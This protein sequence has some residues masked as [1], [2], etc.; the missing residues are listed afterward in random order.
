MKFFV[1]RQPIFDRSSKVF[2]Y[3]LLFRTGV[4]M[5]VPVISGSQASATVISNSFLNLG[6]EHFTGGKRAFINFTPDLIL[7]QI[8]TL[9][10]KEQIV[11]E[12]IEHA[13]PTPE[14]LRECAALKDAGYMIALDDYDGGSRWRLFVEFADIIKVDFVATSG[15][16]RKRLAR[17]L[18]GGQAMLLAEKVETMTEYQ[19]AADLGFSAFQG[20][21]FAR[22][23]LVSGQDIPGLKLNALRLSAEITRRD[24]DFDKLEEIIKRDVSLSYRLLRFINTAAFGWQRRIESVRH[25]LVLLGQREVRRW[26]MLVAI[27]GILTDRPEELLVQSVIR[28]RFCEQLAYSLGMEGRELELYLLGLFSSL[29][30]ILDQPMDKVLERVPLSEEIRAALA[31]APSPPRTA[32]ELALAYERGEWERVAALARSLAIDEE[33]LPEIYGSAVE[34]TA[35]AFRS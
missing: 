10:P 29:D 4:E 31:G 3:E 26:I 17:D 19:E 27:A 8:P 1:A 21:F 25:A 11:V 7:K 15:S 18:G 12:I 30:A 6:L 35:R 33:S 20:F 5:C 22:P 34:W 16:A 13:E 28:A 32:L 23:Q 9:I 14:L 24:C 2:A